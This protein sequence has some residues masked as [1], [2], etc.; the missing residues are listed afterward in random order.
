[1]NIFL[2]VQPSDKPKTGKGFFCLRLGEA[3][4]KMGHKIVVN[5][6]SP[7]DVSLHLAKMRNGKGKRILRL[8]GV[9]H[10]NSMNVKARNSGLKKV[11][12]A[13]NGVIYQSQFSKK[14]CD[15]YLGKFSGPTC[16]IPNG[17]DP[18]FYQDIAPLKLKNRNV[19]L[20]AS[21]WRPHKRLMDI[22]ESFHLADIEDSHL[23]I[24]GDLSKSGLSKNQ[25][26]YNFSSERVTHLGR[27][28]QK[29]LGGYLK[30][31]KAFIHLCWFDNCPN[32]VIES[33][34]AGIPVISNNVGGTHEIVS[35]S[36]GFVC[37]ID[38]PYNLK[39]VRLYSPP[40]IDR[41]LIAEAMRK[42]LESVR[43][44]NSHVDISVIAKK[45]ADF[46]EGVVNG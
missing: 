11:L 39:P 27:M 21:R 15:R 9:C 30:S 46:F 38:S 17:A 32:A 6:S 26:A 4:T 19:F 31:S 22:I 3:L 24:A 1:M 40:K 16:V 28:N 29:Q 8:N 5:S 33:I 41:N 23:Y 18:E 7:H 14:L 42:C 37:P 13:A 45:Y 20:S 34:C 2:P 44:S 12:R 43:V 35:P 10:N 36:G 25:I